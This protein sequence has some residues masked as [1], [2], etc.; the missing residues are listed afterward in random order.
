ME[1]KI[2]TELYKMTAIMVV[3]L[4]LGVYAHD[5]VIAGIQA[6]VALNS[7]IFILFGLAAWLGFRHVIDLKNEVTALNALKAD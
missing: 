7:S 2:R 5:F 3:L 4:G 6:K 1:K